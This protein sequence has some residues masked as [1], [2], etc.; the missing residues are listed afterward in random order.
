MSLIKTNFEMPRGSDPVKQASRLAQDLSS[1]FKAIKE[2]IVLI[3][4]NVSGGNILPSQ[5]FSYSGGNQVFLYTIPHPI[6]AI[7]SGYTLIDFTSNVGNVPYEHYSLVR[8]AWTSSTIS[9]KLS[10]YNGLGSG[11]GSFSIK[12]F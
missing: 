1:N 2:Q 11:S 3:G 4:N 6:G 8:T 5:S 12:I 9:F 10:Y 7:P